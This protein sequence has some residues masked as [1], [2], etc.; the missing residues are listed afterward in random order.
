MPGSLHDDDGP[1]KK[2]RVRYDWIVDFENSSDGL[3]L[4]RDTQTANPQSFRTGDGWF[5]YNPAAN[6]AQM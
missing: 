6:L 5:A 1:R 4:M 2:F 3:G